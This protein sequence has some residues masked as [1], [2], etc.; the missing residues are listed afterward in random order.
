MPGLRTNIVLDRSLESRP[1]MNCSRPQRP[2]SIAASN[3]LNAYE[4]TSFASVTQNHPPN[5][6]ILHQLRGSTETKTGTTD[7][8]A[9]NYCRQSTRS[10]FLRGIDNL[11][12]RNT[13]ES[14]SQT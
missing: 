6:L 11:H 9:P 4:S 7:L 1:S 5:K 14:K 2:L 8:Q 12:A 10:F 3:F 13:L